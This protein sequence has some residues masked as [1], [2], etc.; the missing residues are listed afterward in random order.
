MNSRRNWYNSNKSKGSWNW[1]RSKL[2]KYTNWSS[3][4]PIIITIVIM[5]MEMGMGIIKAWASTMGTVQYKISIWGSLGIR[6][7]SSIW[8]NDN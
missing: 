1:F 7:I 4:T 2:R 8:N 3:T 5:G 6:G